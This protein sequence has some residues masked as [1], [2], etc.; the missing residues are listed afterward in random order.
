MPKVTKSKIF[1]EV[2]LDVYNWM[3]TQIENDK[4]MG[5]KTTID[6]YTI[7]EQARQY[8]E[9]QELGQWA[10]QIDYN[11]LVAFIKKY[12]LENDLAKSCFMCDQG[13]E[14]SHMIQ[15][16]WH[17]PFCQKQ[18][19]TQ[20]A[21]EEREVHETRNDQA[22]EN[23][24]EVQVEGNHTHTQTEFE[25][26][27]NN[28]FVLETSLQEVSSSEQIFQSATEEEVDEN[29]NVV[30]DQGYKRKLED[31][32]ENESEKQIKKIKSDLAASL[33]HDV[34][35]TEDTARK[36]LLVKQ[37]ADSKK[38]KENQSNLL[39]AASTNQVIQQA[40]RGVT[41]GSGDGEKPKEKRSNIL[42][43]I[44]SKNITFS[45]DQCGRSFGKMSG[46]K[47]H[48]NFWCDKKKNF[49]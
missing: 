19:I 35:Y 17:S 4:F 42:Q 2:E 38:L 39:H 34:K 8:L 40:A 27:E 45:C 47:C 13:P 11:W 44:Q 29:N 41:T 30:G 22:E 5:N 25:D 26:D 33:P 37:L 16:R 10:L 6:D 31:N 32:E 18:I 3:R 1:Q 7:I 12:K 21:L 36:S 28:K 49:M 48:K 46:V 15:F 23:N 9:D 43:T 24:N 14:S 20:R